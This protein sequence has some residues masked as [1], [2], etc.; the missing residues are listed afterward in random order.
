MA[1]NSSFLPSTLRKFAHTFKMFPHILLFLLSITPFSAQA[2]VTKRAFSNGPVI[3]SNFPDPAFIN[4]G[5]TYYA[6]ATSNGDQNVQ[7]AT[8]PDFD[9]WTVTGSDALP[10]IPSWSTG[11]V[12]APDVVQ[13]VKLCTNLTDIEIDRDR[14]MVLSSCTSPPLPLP[15]RVCTALE[16]PRPRQSRAHIQPAI[17]PSPVL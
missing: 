10:T 14:P 16:L 12:W 1:A 6:F 5:G 8:S 3:T 17:L 15:T 11:D 2:P 13:L 4:V 9:T 7:I